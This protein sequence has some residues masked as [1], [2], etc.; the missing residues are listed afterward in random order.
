MTVKRFIIGIC[1][2]LITSP[3]FIREQDHTAYAQ[4]VPGGRYASKQSL[5]DSAAAIEARINLRLAKL[6]LEESLRVDYKM[7]VGTVDSLMHRLALE[8]SLRVNYKMLVGTTD[9]LMHRLAFID[10][11]GAYGVS[12]DATAKK[13]A[14]PD[15]INDGNYRQYWN[16]TLKGIVIDFL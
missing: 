11:A 1:L 4:V 2:L 5:I 15:S 8:E 13:I 9:S 6:A 16:D 12:I 14:A 7:L 3:L 10:S